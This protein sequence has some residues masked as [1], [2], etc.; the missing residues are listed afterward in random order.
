VHY[1]C[2]ADEQKEEQCTVSK[3]LWGGTLFKGSNIQICFLKQTSLI[4]REGSSSGARGK[5]F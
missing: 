2:C 4:T 1:C 3:S 5:T